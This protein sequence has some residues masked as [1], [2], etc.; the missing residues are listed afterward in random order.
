M[1]KISQE[2]LIGLVKIGENEKS[3]FSNRLLAHYI[4]VW[5]ISM[6]YKDI[7]T[8]KRFIMNVQYIF[9]EEKESI[10][11]VAS[12]V[13]GKLFQGYLPETLQLKVLLELCK[14]GW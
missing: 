10:G 2:K 11:D 5:L 13:Y 9:P 14:R 3:V 1:G 8:R 4:G 6:G 7:E 12:I